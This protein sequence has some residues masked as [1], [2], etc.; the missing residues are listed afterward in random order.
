[1]ISAQKNQQYHATRRS[2]Y[3][4]L[5]TLTWSNRWQIPSEETD[6]GKGLRI[7]RQFLADLVLISELKQSQGWIT[8][9]GVLLEFFPHFLF[10]FSESESWKS[11]VS[12]LITKV[13]T[14]NCFTTPRWLPEAELQPLN[15][16]IGKWLRKIMY[17]HST[18]LSWTNYVIQ[19][20]FHNLSKAQ[21]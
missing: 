16:H 4:L 14:H 5:C 9:F 11:D 13:T 2:R 20:P 19:V 21:V 18:R 17:D 1:M 3:P 8:K 6:S 12:G 7:C 10:F 15:G